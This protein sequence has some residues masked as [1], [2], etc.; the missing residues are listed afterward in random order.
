MTNEMRKVILGTAF[1]V[2]MLSFAS[3]G[4]DSVPPETRKPHPLV[5]H[6]GHAK[7]PNPSAPETI[8]IEIDDSEQVLKHPEHEVILVCPKDIVIW[9]VADGASGVGSFTVDFHPKNN[10]GKLF[11]SND[12]T[13]NSVGSPPQTASE[14]VKSNGQTGPHPHYDKDYVYL[15]QT[16]DTNKAPLH[17][18]D[19]HVIPVGN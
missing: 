17:N 16:F 13:L 15:I 5:A 9:K 6:A 8:T 19:P 7:C 2:L 12:E 14:T 1:V 18:I 10:P 11:E 4:C 3:A